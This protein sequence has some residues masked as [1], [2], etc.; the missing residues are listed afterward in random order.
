M[1]KRDGDAKLAEI[2]ESI[3][4]G[5]PVNE[6][7]LIYLPLYKSKY[8]SIVEMV[9]E[10]ITLAREATDDIS[11][12]QKIVVLTALVTN[13]FIKEEEYKALWEEIRM[14]IDEIKIL[15]FARQDGIEEGIEQGIEQ[16]IVRGI[17]QG[18][19]QVFNVNKMLK[20]GKAIDEISK[21]T[22]MSEEQILKIKDEL[23]A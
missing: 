11:I 17:E 5:E 14:I 3:A 7:E 18:F 21:E 8:K 1:G 10:V 9:T 13:K 15:K 20:K 22:G 19:Q 16:G 4:K 2:K 12:Y 6:L 23:G